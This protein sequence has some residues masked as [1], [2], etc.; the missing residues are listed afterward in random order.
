MTQ[1]SV[2]PA[3]VGTGTEGLDAIL[4]GGLSK[5][6]IHLVH[7]G[8]GTGKTT[9]GVQFLR[10]GAR[11]GERVLFV[12]MLQTKR[13]LEEIFES[14]GWSPEGIDILELP[15][16][17]QEGAMAEQGLFDTTDVQL[18]EATEAIFHALD[19][20][21]PRRMVLDSLG[22]LGLLVRDSAEL[23]RLIVKLKR[24]VARS[25]CTA[26]C[27]TS[28][29]GGENLA[30]AQT[31]VHSVLVLTQERQAYG[32]PRR[33]IE[34]TKARGRGYMG[35]AHD[36][37]IRTG[38]LTIFPRLDLR[39]QDTRSTWETIASGSDELD[40]MLGG[41]L[42]EGTTCLVFGTTGSGKSTLGA[43]YV[44]SAIR[45]G[46]RSAVFLF[47][48][49]EEM[50]LRRTQAMG[51]DIGPHVEQGSVHLTRVDIEEVFPGELVQVI[52]HKVEHD[53]VRLVVIDSLSGYFSALPAE[54]W[55]QTRQLHELLS[56]LSGAGVLTILIVGIHGLFGTLETPVDATYLA[57]A[58]ILMRLF[59][60]G[61]EVRR[62]ISV[63][64]KR[65]GVHD[66][67]IREV[68][69]TSSGL[70]VG[71]PLHQFSQVLTGLPRFEGSET[72]LFNKGT[73]AAGGS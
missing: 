1:P 31:V 22:E 16:E 59:E 46:R 45:G 57:D 63:V 19:H 54:R 69:I 56:Y 39:R 50:F 71:E 26:L 4:L 49:R 43:T 5:G 24:Q 29:L 73:G 55:D 68:R 72:Q 21:K 66:S 48:E 10:E 18:N 60:T 2:T 61:G 33:Q 6:H 41:G 9:L 51:M 40:E 3:L 52:R 23:R 53:G 25:G 36:F 7:G 64:K 28:D 34:V 30:M 14:H 20:V 58:I 27:T 38:G 62:C 37:A 11:L 44:R 65:H 42:E 13:D 15:E 70:Q 32:R 47:D 8:P 17:V 35:G 12:T 67:T